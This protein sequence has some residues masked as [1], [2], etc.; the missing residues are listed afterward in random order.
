MASVQGMITVRAATL[1]DTEALCALHIAAWQAAY[2][3]LIPDEILDSLDL[4]AWVTRRRETFTTGPR[5]I[6]A[7]D[8]QDR[9]LGHTMIDTYRI[10][11]DPDRRDPA[12]GEIWAIYAH[13][14]HWGTGVGHAL[15]QAALAALPQPEVRLWVLEDNPRAR[16]FYERNGL[17][18]DG[19]RAD[20]SPRGSDVRLAEIRYA[21]HR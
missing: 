20:W 15:I 21:I 17:H 3:G 2:R 6:V 13:P 18:P 10:D 5:V 14:D 9:P 12:F 16:S 4:D 7:V 11:Q 1:D 19:T 8:G